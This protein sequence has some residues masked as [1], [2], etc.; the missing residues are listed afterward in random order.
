EPTAYHADVGADVARQILG[1][2][3]G[4]S[5]GQVHRRLGARGRK[6]PIDVAPRDRATPEHQ[7]RRAADHAFNQ[8]HEAAGGQSITGSGPSLDDPLSVITPPA[9]PLRAVRRVV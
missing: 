8:T 9:G 1:A 4:Q 2:R 5:D 6:G 3:L 7:N